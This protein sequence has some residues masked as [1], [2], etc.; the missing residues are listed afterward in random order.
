MNKKQQVLTEKIFSFKNIGRRKIQEDDVFIC[1][2]KDVENVL[3][4]IFFIFDGHGAKNENEGLPMYLIKSGLLYKELK[5]FFK[6]HKLNSENLKIF[7]S[8]LDRTLEKKIKKY[9]GCCLSSVIIS[10]DFIY[11]L[12]LGDTNITIY[13]TDNNLIFKT[14]LHNFKN[15]IELKRFQ[16]NLQEGFLKE[17]RYKGLLMSR[18]LGDYDCKVIGEKC[19]IPIPEIKKINNNKNFTFILKTDGVT[20]PNKIL[21]EKYNDQTI[22]MFLNV[23]KFNDNA[24]MIIFK[25]IVLEK[26]DQKYN[27]SKNENKKEINKQNDYLFL[28]FLKF[29]YN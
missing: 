23:K 16:D 4:N 7:F 8:N 6:I 13:N 25:N 1:D 10:S 15:E 22:D 9:V 28:S 19:L 29:I 17:N 5:E 20:I 26:K 21:L 2:I 24:A 14:S 27:I 12:T 11:T 3:Y 18:S